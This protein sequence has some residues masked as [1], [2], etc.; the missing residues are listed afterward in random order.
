MDLG[1]TSSIIVIVP[2]APDSSRKQVG[3]EE[4]VESCKW[5]LSPGVLVPWEVFILIRFYSFVHIQDKA[6]YPPSVW[7]DGELH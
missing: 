6:Y 4:Q 3:L 7:G 2:R 5:P 1:F